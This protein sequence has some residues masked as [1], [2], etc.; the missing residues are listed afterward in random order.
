M[1]ARCLT[2]KEGLRLAQEQ[3]ALKEAP[4]HK[5]CEAQKQQATKEAE[6]EQLQLERDQNEPFTG[7]LTTKPKPDLQD[8]AQAL[9]LPT[10]GG[11][12]DLLERITHYFDANP[13]L[14]NTSRYKGLFNRSR[15]QRLQVV[16]DENAPD[17][18][19]ALP[20]ASA[21]ASHCSQSNLLPLSFDITNFHYDP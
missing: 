8:V 13:D 17:M 1:N 19:A 11:K 6:C 5:K 15:G 7:A 18:N 4:K 3:Q 12:K 14:Q 16:H 10:T 9:G 21:S 20:T 2:S